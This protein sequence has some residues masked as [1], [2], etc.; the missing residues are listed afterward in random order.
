VA[1]LNSAFPFP[2]DISRGL[3]T[4]FLINKRPDGKFEVARRSRSVRTQG[5]DFDILHTCDTYRDAEKWAIEEHAK[6]GR[7]KSA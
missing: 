3:P 4:G 1:K 2:M 7:F 5:N 6:G